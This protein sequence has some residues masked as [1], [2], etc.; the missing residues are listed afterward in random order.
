MLRGDPFVCNLPATSYSY[1]RNFYI[2]NMQFFSPFLLLGLAT[3][4]FADFHVGESQKQQQPINPDK[5]PFPVYTENVACPSNY[6]NCKCYGDWPK[7]SDRGAI[8]SSRSTTGQY[9]SLKEGLCGMG[10]LD[11]YYRQNLGHWEF[12]VNNGDGKVQ[13]T[14]H[15][16]TGPGLVKSCGGAFSVMSTVYKDQLWCYSYIC[17]K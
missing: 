10:K 14:C 1:L 8:V 12:Y 11:F 2:F 4:G 16:A 6:L 7:R 9:F 3:L 15:K 13:G 5:P 17:G